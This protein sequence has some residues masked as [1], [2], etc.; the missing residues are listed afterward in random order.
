MAKN[1][2]IITD[3]LKDFTPLFKEVKKKTFFTTHIVSYK[4]FMSNEFMD[5]LKE[6]NQSDVIIAIKN[7][8]FNKV[9]DE[10]LP[11]VKSLFL[12]GFNNI[13]H[14]FTQPGM[15]AD[16]D[17]VSGTKH[18]YFLYEEPYFVGQIVNFILY[19]IKI[20]S[21][22]TMSGR[23]LDYITTSFEGIVNEE[24]LKKK[25]KEIE[26]LNEEL[27]IISKTDSLTKI[28]NRKTIFDQLERELK[29][30]KRDLWRIETSIKKDARVNI[31][32]HADHYDYEPIGELLDHYGV[33][34][35][36]MIDVD[37]F[38]LVNDTH[39]H[40]VGDHVLRVIGQ[41]LADKEIFRTNDVS[42]RIG[43]EEFIVILPETNVNNALGPAIRFMNKLSSIEFPGKEDKKF[44]ITVSIG[45]SESSPKDT[46][47]DDIL[48][49]VDKALYWA[50]EHGRDQIVIYEKV[51]DK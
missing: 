40:L 11:Y 36:M 39:G 41:L 44:K 10:F 5:C 46:I 45:I 21:E 50:K 23:L 8:F 24:L 6:I 19:T 27:E 14:I 3:R 37:H 49:R 30:T 2:F 47:K 35:L 29:R 7:D 42:G 12:P 1:F 16:D 28:F 9:K 22:A 13:I 43:G 4:E 48:R 26:K 51:F 18:G 20:F 15:L 25:K 33:Y 34:S 32:S 17:I 31:Q 38:K